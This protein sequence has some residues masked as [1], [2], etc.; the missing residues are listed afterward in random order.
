MAIQIEL[1][2]KTLHCKESRDDFVHADG[3]NCL[4]S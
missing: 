1:E 2:K 4:N 3:E